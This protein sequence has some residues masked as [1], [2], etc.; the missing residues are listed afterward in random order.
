M[1]TIGGY[2]EDASGITGDH[3]EPE[4]DYHRRTG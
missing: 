2:A 3:K 4:C 1:T